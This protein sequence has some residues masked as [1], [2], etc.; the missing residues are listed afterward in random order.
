MRRRCAA[1]HRTKSRHEASGAGPVPVPGRKIGDRDRRQR[2]RGGVGG[3]AVPL[4]E[5]GADGA[6]ARLRHQVFLRAEVA[7]E[8]AM[9]EP[10]A[11]HQIGNA[12]AVKAAL[13]EQ[14]GRVV[15]NALPGGGRLLFGHLHR[16]NPSCPHISGHEGLTIS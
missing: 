12:D 13:A 11:F 2:V 5:H 15:Q 3:H 16:P 6:V 10:D 8:S 14:L 4:L 9:R 7:V 1:G